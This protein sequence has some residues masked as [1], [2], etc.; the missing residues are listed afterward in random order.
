MMKNQQQLTAVEAMNQAFATQGVTVAEGTF[1]GMRIQ[2]YFGV[3]VV[4]ENPVVLPEP[5]AADHTAADQMKAAFVAMGVNQLHATVF[6]VPIAEFFGRAETAVW[7]KILR[8]VAAET[9]AAATV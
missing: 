5:Q 1:F 3:P 9:A 4:S 7:E 6:G 8:E 2:D